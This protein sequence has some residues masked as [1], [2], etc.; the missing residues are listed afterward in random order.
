M[1]CEI[2]EEKLSVACLLMH[3]NANDIIYT[4]VFELH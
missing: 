1:P 4:P 3:R 2:Q